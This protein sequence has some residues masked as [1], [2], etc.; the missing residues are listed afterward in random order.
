MAQIAMLALAVGGA[1]YS[2]WQAKEAKDEQKQAI[3]RQEELQQRR[4]QDKKKKII[5]MQRASLAASGISLHSGLANVMMEDTLTASQE[6]ANLIA[7]YYETQISSVKSQARSTY[8]SAIGSVGSSAVSA[9][10][11]TAGSSGR[12]SIY[13]SVDAKTGNWTSPTG[14]VFNYR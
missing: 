1:G 11:S 10:G 14:Q 7:D 6:E 5:G 9:Y 2:A 13:G 3:Y 4:L 12:S 8:A